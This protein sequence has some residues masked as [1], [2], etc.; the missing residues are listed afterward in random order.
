MPLL[1]AQPACAAHVAAISAHM[2]PVMPPPAPLFQATLLQPHWALQLAALESFVVYT[3]AAPANSRSVIPPQLLCEP[4]KQ[5]FEAK[6]RCD[7]NMPKGGRHRQQ[8]EP[9]CL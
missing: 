7:V 5:R 2:A 3:R 6:F 4:Q 1:Q 9:T 8:C